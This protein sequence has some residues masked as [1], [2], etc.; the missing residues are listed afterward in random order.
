M[1]TWRMSCPK[2]ATGDEPTFELDP[3]LN[4]VTREGPARPRT[5]QYPLAADRG[6]RARCAVLLYSS[7]CCARAA[8]RVDDGAGRMAVI[9]PRARGSLESGGSLT[10][11]SRPIYPTGRSYDSLAGAKPVDTC[12][13]VRWRAVRSHRGLGAGDERIAQTPLRLVGLLRGGSRAGLARGTS[14]RAAC[15]GS[16]VAHDE[17]GLSVAA[18][19]SARSVVRGS[20][21]CR[22]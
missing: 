13:R 10:C 7:A 4:V 22:D 21:P 9:R 19:A 17:R 1:V 5:R 18:E 12:L 16:G 8:R 20:D 2:A 3:A 14:G 11:Q 6:L 15:V